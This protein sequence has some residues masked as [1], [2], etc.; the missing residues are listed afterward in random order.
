MA[1]PRMRS[2]WMPLDLSV[3]D[4]FL[5]AMVIT[6][7]FRQVP[8]YSR[9]VRAADASHYYEGLTRWRDIVEHEVRLT[10]GWAL[11]CFLCWDV[12][13]FMTSRHG[14][15]AGEL[16]RRLNAQDPA[17]YRRMMANQ[18]E[19]RGH[20]VIRTNQLWRRLPGWWAL[21]P[22]RRMVNLP[23]ALAWTVFDWIVMWQV[24]RKLVS[25]HAIGYW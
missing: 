8:D 16:V 17:W 19:I 12:L 7:N 18:I 14:P 2:I 23:A 10:V 6:D 3:E 15:G 20:W 24:N 25:G 22:G 4:G 11:N 21:P 9:V 13:L 5:H 1:A